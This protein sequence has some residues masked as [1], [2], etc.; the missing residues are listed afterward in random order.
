MAKR[1]SQLVSAL[2]ARLRKR[3][4]HE[5]W[6]QRVLADRAG[7]DRSYIAGIEAGLRNPSVKALHKVARGLGVSL[8]QLVANID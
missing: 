5:T 6:T 4:E 1:P 7:L 8:S 2:G 3:R